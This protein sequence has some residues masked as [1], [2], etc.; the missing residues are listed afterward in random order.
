MIILKVETVNGYVAYDGTRFD[1]ENECCVHEARLDSYNNAVEKLPAALADI[2]LFCF[3]TRMKNDCC[4]CPIA[5]LCH[6]RPPLFESLEV[7][8][9]Y[10][11]QTDAWNDVY[12]H[13]I[14]GVQDD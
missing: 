13:K 4:V 2:E 6:N 7:Y 8:L 3:M 14:T 1:N 11:R 5:E 9:N 10:I 12:H